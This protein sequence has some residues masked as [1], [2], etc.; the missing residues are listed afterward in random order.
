MV[1]FSAP[2]A[3]L[4]GC[5]CTALVENA[6]YA[7]KIFQP[8]Q[9]RCRR[10]SEGQKTTLRNKTQQPKTTVMLTTWQTEPASVLWNRGVAAV[11]AA[12]EVSE[13]ER[14]SEHKRLAPLSE[15][16]LGARAGWMGSTGRCES[17]HD[18]SRFSPCLPD[19]PCFKEHRP[20]RP[21]SNRN[22]LLPSRAHDRHAWSPQWL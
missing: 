14:P 10:H 21:R 12:T 6:L 13:A 18:R 19:S 2:A 8:L 7:A 3:S 11:A 1:I 20:A 22:C 5:E 16:R 4:S 17:I 9:E 15:Q